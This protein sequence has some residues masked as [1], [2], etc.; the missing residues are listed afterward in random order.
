MVRKTLELLSG[1]LQ[2]SSSVSELKAAGRQGL[3]ICQLAER[4][5]LGEC[6]PLAPPSPMIGQVSC[7]LVVHYGALVA[8]L[9][10]SSLRCEP[11]PYSFQSI[12]VNCMSRGGLVELLQHI[13]P[14]LPHALI[15]PSVQ[16]EVVQMGR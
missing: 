2:L 3:G 15:F 4:Q 12:E 7:E 8:K 9:S 5:G 13:Q 11:P 10:S 1:T 14:P 6:K 16:Y